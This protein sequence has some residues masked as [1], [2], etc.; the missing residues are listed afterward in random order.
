MS[1]PS[2]LLGDKVITDG[3]EARD[4]LLRLVHEEMPQRQRTMTGR[5][6][7][8]KDFNRRYPQEAPKPIVA[9]IDEYAQL[10]SIMGRAEREAFER[11]LMSLAQ[12][13][14]STGIH[15]VLATQ[16][17]SADIVTGTLRG[18]LAGRYRIQG[19]WFC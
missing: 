9:V 5:S 18:E 13:A 10:I 14:R 12:V 8:V 2:Y 6:L 17:P 15:L 19:S 3:A 7:R 16:R 11:D 1:A 4:A